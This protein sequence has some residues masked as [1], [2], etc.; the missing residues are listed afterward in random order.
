MGLYTPWHL[1]KPKYFPYFF[2]YQY[3]LP[4]PDPAT[5]PVSEFMT[6]VGIIKPK[7]RIDKT[8]HLGMPTKIQVANRNYKIESIWLPSF[9][10]NQALET[11][12]WMTDELNSFISL[13]HSIRTWYA[14]QLQNVLWDDFITSVR[15]LAPGD[16]NAAILESAARILRVYFTC[17]TGSLYKTGR[18]TFSPGKHTESNLIT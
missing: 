4:Y 6:V 14:L 18:T 17:V 12:S 8:L 10:A 7:P 13:V 5:Y 16:D 2:S 3:L 1:L 9:E 15:T 11:D